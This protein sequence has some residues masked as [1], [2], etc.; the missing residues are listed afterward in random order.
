MFFRRS[1]LSDV[2]AWDERYFG[3]WVDTDWCHSLRAAGRHIFCVPAAHLVHHE[4]NARGKR[5]TP[6]RIWMFHYGAYQLYTRWRTLGY[7]DPR[8]IVAGLALLTRALLLMAQNS[9]PQRRREETAPFAR[10][11]GVQAES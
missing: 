3:Y 10:R 9:L 8:S 6:S 2:G 5:K 1:L 4:N 11:P 7:W